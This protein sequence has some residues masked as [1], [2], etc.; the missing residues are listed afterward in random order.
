[1]CPPTYFDIEYSINPYMDVENKVDK[2]RARQQWDYA[3]EVLKSLQVEIEVIEPLP[4]LPDM[5]FAG[6]CGM[7]Y[8][9]RFIASNFRYVE[10]IGEVAPYADWLAKHGFT[11]YTLPEGIFFEGLGDII[12]FDNDILFG[13]GPRSSP[14]AIEH[15]K[16][17]LPELNIIGELHL[18]DLNFYHTAL[19]ISLIDKDTV[20]YYPEAFTLESRQFI[21]RRFERAVAVSERDAKEYFVCNNIPIERDILVD[22]CTDE[23][24]MAL[25]KWGYRAV[26]CDMSEFKKSGGSVRCLILN[27]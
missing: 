10:R 19:A 6:D 16:H 20:L 25:E 15:V 3:Y 1:M 11:I 26:K 8:G 18:Q 17:I 13:F 9:N 22:D 27:L 21:E 24:R 4:G 14:E 5:T 2:K 23:L 7:V 12:Y